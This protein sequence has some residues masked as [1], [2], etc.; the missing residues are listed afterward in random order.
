MKRVE[1]WTFLP[2]P[3]SAKTTL[4]N[5]PTISEANIIPLAPKY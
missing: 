2:L 1:M 5:S 4:S 3:S